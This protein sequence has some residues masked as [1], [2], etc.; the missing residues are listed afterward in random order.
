MFK[1]PLEALA[2]HRVLGPV[3]ARRKAFKILDGVIAPV[4]VSM[5]DLPSFRNRAEMVFPNMPMKKSAPRLRA[6]KIT[7]VSEAAT[8]WV[9]AVSMAEIFDDLGA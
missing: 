8:F 6:V 2:V 1:L 5:V 9:P 4:S 3:L 7:P